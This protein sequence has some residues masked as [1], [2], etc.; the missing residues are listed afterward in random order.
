MMGIA[1]AQPILRATR[2]RFAALPPLANVDVDIEINL[3][4]AGLRRAVG[5]A[6]MPAAV[7][8]ARFP[9]V[10]QFQTSPLRQLT[11]A[12]AGKLPGQHDLF[13]VLAGPDDV[14]TQ[15]APAAVI[16]ADHLLPGEDGVAEEI[17]GGAGQR[18]KCS[19]FV[20]DSVPQ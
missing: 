18:R 6:F 16:A 7:A 15:F 10:R 11:A 5:A 9:N 1:S 12:F 20:P 3:A 13:T 17:V 2:F 8:G 14:R 4:D 19:C